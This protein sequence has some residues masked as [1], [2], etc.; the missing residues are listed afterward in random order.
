MPTSYFWLTFTYNYNRDF[1]SPHLVTAPLE[2]VSPAHRDVLRARIEPKPLRGSLMASGRAL[3]NVAAAP[4]LWEGCH[5]AASHGPARLPAALPLLRRSPLRAGRGM[6]ASVRVGA[7]WAVR[8]TAA[9]WEGPTSEK[10]RK[11]ENPKSGRE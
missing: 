9:Q 8:V 3:L 10:T 1:M 6:S 5:S 11:N 7:G 2:S 4:P